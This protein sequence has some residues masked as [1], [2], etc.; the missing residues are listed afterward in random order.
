MMEWQPIETAPTDEWLLGW[1]PTW[2][3]VVICRLSV[4]YAEDNAPKMT[5]LGYDHRPLGGGGEVPHKWFRWPPPE[6]QP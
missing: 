6:G 5:W 1:E 3:N 2:D 4:S